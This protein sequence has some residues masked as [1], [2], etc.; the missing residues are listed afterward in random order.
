MEK[1]KDFCVFKSVESDGSLNVKSNN[2]QEGETW[3]VE[4]FG[5]IDFKT[6]TNDSSVYVLSFADDVQRIISLSG[7]TF[8]CSL[9]KLYEGTGR[10]CFNI[11]MRNESK[12]E[13]ELCFWLTLK[14]V[15]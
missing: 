11:S 6:G 13:K 5:A 14:R 2:L 4:K 3:K 7:N 12:K 15:K 9:D 8:E 1:L 10:H